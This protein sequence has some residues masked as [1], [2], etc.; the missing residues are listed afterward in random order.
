[1]QG[2]SKYWPPTVQHEEVIEVMTTPSSQFPMPT[3]NDQVWI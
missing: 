1:M 2:S 3:F